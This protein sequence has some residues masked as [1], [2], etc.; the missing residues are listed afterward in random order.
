MRIQNSIKNMVFGLSGQIISMAIG[1]IVRTVFIY[2]LGVEYLGVEGLFTSILLMLSLANLGFD[3]AIIYSLYKP[4]AE[5][6]VCK[7]QALMNLYR[8]AYRII[9][10]IVLIIGLSLFPFLPYLMNGETNINNIDLIYL[11]F[12]IQSVSSYYF[13][14][15][16]SVIIADQRNH[17]ISKIHSVFIIVS[18]FTQIILLL[19]VSN[20]ILI[21][22]IQIGFRIFENIYI[23]NKA[24]E[25][26]PYLK[27]RNNASL[28]SKDKKQFY[29]NLYSLFLYRISGVVINGTDNIII[30]TFVGI[31]WVGIYSN[32]LL[33]I[34]TITTFLGYFFYSVTASV[35]NLNVNE[36]KEK[37]HFIFRVIN[38]TNFWLYGFCTVCLWN[39]VNPFISLWLG[40]QYLL[41]KFIVF[42]ILLNFYTTGMQNAS[43]TFRETTGLFKKGK[44]RPVIAAL[45]NICVSIILTQLMGISGVFLGTVISRLCT[46]F[47]YDPYIIFKNVFHRPIKFYY[48]KYIF[49]IMLVIGSCIISNFIISYMHVNNSLINLVIGGIVCL[50]VPNFLFF[51]I[52]RKSHEFIYL[53]NIVKLLTNNVSTT[54]FNKKNYNL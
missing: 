23:R 13:A 37:K 7:I 44:Y 11:L 6:D 5:N 47:W 14:Y 36:S 46:F 34:T 29:E 17:V 43:T 45:I 1:I 25:L 41:N 40:E 27:T 53:W 16:H 48:L 10:V 30:S 18:N 22:T 19:T 38:F 12:L 20:Y 3:T 49:F 21:L 24:D 52:F 33:I 35:G 54:L 50:I 9:G 51:L 31:A 32:Y 39:L 28:T 26:Y 8:N 42:T 4:L 2:T 15:K